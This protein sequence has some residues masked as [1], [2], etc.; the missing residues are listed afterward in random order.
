MK[1]R[2][3]L[4]GL[5]AAALVLSLAAGVHAQASQIDL[6]L[7]LQ[8]GQ[9]YNLRMVADTSMVQT[10]E[11]RAISLR[12]AFGY[13]LA[14]A[15]EGVD[16]DGTAT[17][18]ATFSTVLFRLD[19]VIGATEYDSTRSTGAVPPLAKGFAA[20][21]GRGFTVRVAPDGQVKD[22][23]GAEQLLNHVIMNIADLVE[24]VKSYMEDQLRESFT[25][26]SLKE[27]MESLFG[28]VPGRPVSVGERWS[29]SRVAVS[30][31][32]HVQQNYLR[33]TDRADGISNVKVY[34]EVKANPNA[35][36]KE[37]GPLKTKM[38][39][40]GK[41]EGVVSLD[42][43]TGLVIRGSLSGRFTGTIEVSGSAKAVTLPLTVT[44]STTF[45]KR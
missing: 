4:T 17:V 45:E 19:G 30:G 43:S 11:G 14:L 3:A 32:P 41:Q 2:T 26:Q 27:Q 6:K 23:Q 35:P 29:K 34:T 12:Q 22:V 31:M 39:V 20:L 18:K 15:C 25:A 5:L 28:M 37:A 44:T 7:R 8:P 40:S 1:A 38:V 33:I 24:P 36:A 10:V 16:P 21:V 9:T 42:E 13:G